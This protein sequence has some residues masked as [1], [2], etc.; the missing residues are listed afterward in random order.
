ER[1][2]RGV[3]IALLSRHQIHPYEQARSLALRDRGD[4]GGLQ[5]E[6]V[7][8]GARVDE[9]SALPAFAAL[10]RDERVG[11]RARGVQPHLAVARE[12]ALVAPE[13]PLDRGYVK[14]TVGIRPRRSIGLRAHVDVVATHAVAVELLSDRK[15]QAGRT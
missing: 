11:A 14:L 5:R 9:P 6:G 10:R 3:R 15:R 4:P 8:E 7:F 1:A 13:P 2:A 12:V